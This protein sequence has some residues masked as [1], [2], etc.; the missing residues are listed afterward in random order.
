MDSVSEH[1]LCPAEDEGSDGEQRAAWPPACWAQKVRESNTVA[2]SNT[3]AL[4]QNGNIHRLAM[5]SVEHDYK[6]WCWNGMRQNIPQIP[7]VS[8]QTALCLF[9][10][11]R[12]KLNLIL[13]LSWK[14][15]EHQA[16][17]NKQ[18]NKLITRKSSTLFI[19]SAFRNICFLV[20]T[21]KLHKVVIKG[22]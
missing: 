6:T 19:M 5:M 9:L 1:V 10:L 16:T 11:C 7:K 17:T 22:N 14:Y 21:I 12:E 15:K 4:N 8:F 13:I 20:Y 2:N 3:D 18:N